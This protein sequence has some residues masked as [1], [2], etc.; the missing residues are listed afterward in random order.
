MRVVKRKDDDHWIGVAEDDMNGAV[1]WNRGPL[2]RVVMLVD[3]D[4]CDLLFK[5]S[6]SNWLHVSSRYEASF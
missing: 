4:K 2:V 6:P 1:Q 5:R 3:N